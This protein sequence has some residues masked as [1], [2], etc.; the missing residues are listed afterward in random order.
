MT[1][2][3]SLVS[4]ADREATIRSSLDS[5]TESVDFYE[6]K[7]TKTSLK[8]IRVGIDL[9]V[10]R[11]SNF[12]TFSRQGAYLAHHE[13]DES[14]FEHGQESETA[15]QVQHEILSELART[16]KGDSVKP[17][18]DVLASAG[19][20]EPLLIT[21]GGVVVNGN[22]R[23]A[24]MRELFDES[25]TGYSGFSH[26]DCM[27]LPEDATAE[28]ILDVEANLQGKP[29]TRL[30]Y[31]WIG[32]GR[33]L[34]ALSD[35]HGDS[36][37][38]DLMNRGLKEVK[39]SIAALTEADLY[40]REWKRKPGEYDLVVKDGEQFFKDLAQHNSGKDAHLQEASRVIAWMLFDNRSKLDGRLYQYNAAFGKLSEDVL[41]RVSETLQ[42]DPDAPGEV[43][44][45]GIEFSFEIDELEDEPT[46]E[47]VVE[48]LS[49]DEAGDEVV[50]ALIDAVQVAIETDKGR[51]SGEAAL[52]AV[53]QAQAK[54]AAV[55]I[56]RA[57][58]STY[59]GIRNQLGSIS[60]RVETLL[61]VL[62]EYEE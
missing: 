15:Q 59:E 10:Y 12:R 24:A 36:R 41:A 52:K 25:N 50:D 56:S 29:E 58:R 28:D 31:D 60:Q 26:V 44:D 54:L 53:A 49:D 20:Q 57:D 16:G 42:I 45:S 46:F 3:V 22:R 11:M 34:S 48:A 19:Q 39:T 1:Y 35:R 18:I 32:D 51:K 40:L 38:A 5:S 62:S 6:Y 9:P 23:L 61:E 43:D 37:A 13:L 8:K 47:A 2:V 4:P 33:L 27:V 55:D 14:F 17:I 30:D 7:N 21:S